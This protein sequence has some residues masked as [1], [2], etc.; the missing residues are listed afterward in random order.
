[1][2]N[3]AA[4]DGVGE[5]GVVL[6]L[7]RRKSLGRPG[8]RKSSLGPGP[9]RRQTAPADVGP[10]ISQSSDSLLG[11]PNPWNASGYGATGSRMRKLSFD[12][13]TG[14]I[15]LDDD[16][17]GDDLERGI[18]G[19]PVVVPADHEHTSESDSEYGS[20]SSMSGEGHAALSTADESGPGPS[21]AASSGLLGSGTGTGASRHRTYYHHPEK[22]KSM[23]QQ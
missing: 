16:D 21:T 15:N 9:E 22:R 18:A 5:D 4:E 17:H 6:T 8:L 19:T 23:V 11:A 12:A 10:G 2:V 13:A 3:G 14:V 1:V 20:A 7:R